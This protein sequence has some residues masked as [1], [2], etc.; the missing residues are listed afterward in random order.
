MFIQHFECLFMIMR[1][2]KESKYQKITRMVK[3]YYT[4]MMKC[5]KA[6]KNILK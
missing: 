6:I 4:Q 3:V 5:Y 2:W 1:N